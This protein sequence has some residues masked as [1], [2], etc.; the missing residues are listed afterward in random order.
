MGNEGATYIKDFK[1][2]LKKAKKNENPPVAKYSVVLN[3][4][5]VYRFS[6]CSATEFEGKAI[7]QLYDKESMLGSNY[8]MATGKEYPSFDFYCKKSGIYDVFMSFKGGAEGCAAGILS[9]VGKEY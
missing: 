7:I 2:R 4:N 5:T 8:N 1:V 3:K 6:V 9:F